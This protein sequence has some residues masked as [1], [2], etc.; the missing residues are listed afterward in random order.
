M[1]YRPFYIIVLWM[2]CLVD[3]MRFVLMIMQGRYL[4]NDSNPRV[5]ITQFET[6]IRANPLTFCVPN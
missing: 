6:N 5:C 2:I 3:G 1:E 4:I